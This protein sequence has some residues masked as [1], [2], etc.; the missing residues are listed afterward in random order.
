MTSTLPTS[1]D[2]ERLAETPG[3][4]SALESERFKAFLDHMPIAVAV[5]EL[6]DPETIVYANPEFERVCGRQASALAQQQWGVLEGERAEQTEGPTLVS[7]ILHGGD[8]VERFR[9]RRPDDVVVVELHSNVIEDEAGVPAYRLVALVGTAMSEADAQSVH[10]RVRDKDTQLLELQHRVKNNLQLITGLIR[11]ESRNSGTADPHSYERL[12]GR[13]E[14]LAL[15]YDAMSLSDHEGEVDLGAYLG[16]V[17]TAVMASHA[18]EG[19]RLDLRVDA[20][21]ASINVAM[22]TGLVVNELLMNALKHAFR[23]RDA[24]TITLHSVV[25]GSVC[26]IIVADDG[27]GL[28]AGESWPKRGRLGALIAESLRL[29]A[30]AQMSVASEPDKGTTVTITFTRSVAVAG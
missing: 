13:V 5:S 22:P 10:A 1:E 3:L 12:A 16:Q 7:A 25:D 29:N 15:L 24:G 19:I 11:L 26:T 28:P 21:L 8:R 9:I 27:V 17:A 18:V 23:G 14:S 4:A 2:V 30:R 20:Y 6:R